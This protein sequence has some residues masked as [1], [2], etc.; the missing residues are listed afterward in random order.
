MENENVI[1]E[2]GVIELKPLGV[3]HDTGSDV[4]APKINN[5]VDQMISTG[6]VVIIYQRRSL[7]SLYRNIFRRNQ[8]LN[9]GK[10]PGEKGFVE[11][12]KL[13]THQ[14]VETNNTGDGKWF[15]RLCKEGETM[16]PFYAIENHTRYG[17]WL[18]L[19]DKMMN[20]ERV[21]VKDLKDA[22]RLSQS[23]RSLSERRGLFRAGRM[24]RTSMVTSGRRKSY[25]VELVKPLRKK[26]DVLAEIE[27]QSAARKKAGQAKKA[28]K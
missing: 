14:I 3:L 5:A 10:K 16:N 2:A 4:W 6:C 25:L 1:F 24:L 26:E 15:V 18:V 27:I 19:A 22:R 7:D 8:K 9:P 21:E 20:G 13:W 11:K 12:Y 23:F 17:H 28:A